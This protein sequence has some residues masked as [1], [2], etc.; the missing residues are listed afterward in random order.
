MNSLDFWL[1]HLKHLEATKKGIEK[2][3]ERTKRQIESEKRD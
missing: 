3:I 2:A 1:D